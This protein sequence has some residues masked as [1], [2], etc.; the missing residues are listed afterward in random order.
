VNPAAELL[1]HR[2]RFQATGIHA[3]RNGHLERPIVDERLGVLRQLVQRLW[4]RLPFEQHHYR[5]VVS[6]DVD[7]PSAYG[8][9]RKRSLVRTMAERLLKHRGLVG[10]LQAPRIRLASHRQLHS[11]DSF[12]S[13]EWLMDQIDPTGIQSAFYFIC[14]RTDLRLDAHYKSEYTAIRPLMRRIQQCGHEINLHPSAIVLK[15]ARLQLIVREEG[16]QQSEWGGRVHSLRWQWPITV[17]G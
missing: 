5:I 15:A 1:D 9:G 4:P 8:F 14:G 13:F 16:I 10:P 7:A 2:R 6:H 3:S 11:E 17:H 12:N